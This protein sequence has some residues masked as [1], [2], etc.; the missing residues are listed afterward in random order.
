MLAV[1]LVLSATYPGKL[2]ATSA[3]QPIRKSTTEL[4]PSG[5]ALLKD[6]IT[7]HN[8]ADVAGDGSRWSDGPV[9]L[10]CDQEYLRLCRFAQ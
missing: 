2:S 1:A 4:S 6:A 8:I 7:R 10:P 3:T 9:S 5:N